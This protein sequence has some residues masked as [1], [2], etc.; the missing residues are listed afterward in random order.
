MIINILGFQIC[1]FGLVLFGNSFVPI[2][3]SLLVIHLI[4]LS[5][6]ENELLLVA[7]I[8][9]VGGLVDSLLAL[10]AIFVFSSSLFIPLWLIVLWACFASTIT[11]SLSFLK[12]WPL[13]QV[14]AGLFIAPLSY[15]A[16]NKLNVVEF[17]YS[18]LITYLMLGV[19]WSVLLLLFFRLEFLLIQENDDAI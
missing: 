2:A 4:F 12:K 8:V 7:T 17:S 1:W 10:S 18:P 9:C 16:G 14:V 13:L 3:I 11:H 19:I 15:I 5:K 6:G